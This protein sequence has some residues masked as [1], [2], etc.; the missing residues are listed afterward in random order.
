MS[1]F[2]PDEL[3][4]ISLSGGIW[5]KLLREREARILNRIYGEF[6]NGKTDHT[7]ALAEFCSVR[8][9][10]QEITNSLREQAKEN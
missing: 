6:R 3:R 8:D 9:Q 7:A 4:V 1:K 5:L 10:I 2:T